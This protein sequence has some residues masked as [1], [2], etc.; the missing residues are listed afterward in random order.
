MVNIGLPRQELRVHGT[1]VILSAAKN[2]GQILRCAQNDGNGRFVL[3]KCELLLAA[4]SA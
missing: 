3:I 2:L 4:V 1:I